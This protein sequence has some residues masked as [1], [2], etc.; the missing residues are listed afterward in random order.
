MILIVF[1]WKPRNFQAYE[2]PFE[3]SNVK[4]S[5]KNFIFLLIEA[6]AI[7]FLVEIL[8]KMIL[9]VYCNITFGRNSLSQF[10]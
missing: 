2:N 3:K 9:V 4:Q 10:D 1:V 7:C 5:F 8:V 6:S